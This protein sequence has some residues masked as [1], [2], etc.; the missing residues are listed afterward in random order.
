[1]YIYLST[2]SNG[3][4]LDIGAQP[5]ASNDMPECARFVRSI[6]LTLVTRDNFVAAVNEHDIV[7]SQ[8]FAVLLQ[9][10]CASSNDNTSSRAVQA[11]RR[12]NMS[13]LARRELLALAGGDVELDEEVLLVTPAAGSNAWLAR[14]IVVAEAY[15]ESASADETSEDISKSKQIEKME[16]ELA[17]VKALL[18]VVA[19]LLEL[20]ASVRG[21]GEAADVPRRLGRARSSS[22]SSLVGAMDEGMYM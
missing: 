4:T 20:R 6:A 17:N 14:V 10:A 22:V 16:G 2:C 19:R 3:D 7:A 11:F 18:R 13:G 15:T 9:L 5:L 21:D 8:L 1:M 12:L